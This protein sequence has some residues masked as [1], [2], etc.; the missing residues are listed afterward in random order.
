[1]FDR[2]AYWKKRNEEKVFRE[3]WTTW[4]RTAEGMY[5]KGFVVT[6]RDHF[7][8]AAFRVYKETLATMRAEELLSSP[9]TLTTAIAGDTQLPALEKGTVN[10]SAAT[11]EIQLVT[12]PLGEPAII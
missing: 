5:G 12:L 3:E 4:V 7:T 9:N 1:M 10:E 8:Q 6:N 2:E 11:E